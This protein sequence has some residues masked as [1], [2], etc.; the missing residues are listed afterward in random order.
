MEP[1]PIKAFSDNYIWMIVVADNV[2]CVDPGDATPVIRF[3]KE[4]GLNLS[5]ILLTHHH[6]DHIGG[7]SELAAHYPGVPIYGP[8]EPRIPLEIN[9]VDENS[10]L[11]LLSF[12]FE[13]LLTPGHTKTHLCY[14]EKQHQW[15]FCGDTLFSAGCG[16]VFDGTIEELYHSL[17]K[18][19]ALTDTTK[20][21]CAHEYTLKNLQFA[22]MI[23]P[24]NKAIQERILHLSQVTCSLPSTIQLEKLINPFFR[25]EQPKIQEY[26]QKKSIELMDS[27]AIFKQLRAEKDIF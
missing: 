2:L 22:A 12:T 18:L 4:N 1:I 27:F 10:K 19:R 3:L 23:E 6:A 14:H 16:R 26:F 7:I 24:T 5:A 25:T 17:L 21:F 15:L 9:V 11:S 8:C 20:V 13:I